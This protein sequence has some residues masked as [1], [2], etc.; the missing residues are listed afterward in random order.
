VDFG[1]VGEFSPRVKGAMSVDRI[2]RDLQSR[3]HRG[4]KNVP[5][6]ES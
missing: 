3:E 2:E 5:P 4:A 1:H 6:T